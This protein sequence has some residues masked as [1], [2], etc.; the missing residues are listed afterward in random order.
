[1][2]QLL[3]IW[4][5]YERPSDFPDEFVAR[6]YLVGDGGTNYGATSTVLRAPDLDGIRAK[7]PRGLWRVERSP[8][9]DPVIV[10]SWL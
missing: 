1:M 9:D 3:H 7:L 6:L 8:T 2:K 4:T 5:V 10:E